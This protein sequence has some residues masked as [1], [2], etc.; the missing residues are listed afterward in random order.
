M[1]VPTYYQ[2]NKDK[3]SEN[4]KNY[5]QQHKDNIKQKTKQ[6]QI[7]ERERRNIPL[8]TCEFCE[9][10]GRKYINDI[11]SIRHKYWCRFSYSSRK[12]PL[13]YVSF[14]IRK[15]FEISI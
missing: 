9:Y 4:N 7:E 13:N 2:K 15:V 3:C 14:V 6:R 8:A 12:L 10:C 1:E 5:Y 11:N